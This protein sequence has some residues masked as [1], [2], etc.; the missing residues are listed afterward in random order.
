MASTSK[1]TS[2]KIK[3]APSV[4]ARKLIEEQTAAFLRDGGAIQQIPNGITGQVNLA[5]P[6][7][8]VLAKSGPNN[9]VD[10]LSGRR[11]DLAPR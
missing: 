10:A 4:I 11:N 8:I 5:G 7:Q 6:R 2:E 9:T 1:K 3:Q